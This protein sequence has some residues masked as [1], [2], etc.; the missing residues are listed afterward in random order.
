ML[1]KSF[2]D[3]NYKQLDFLHL[4]VRLVLKLTM[5][6]HVFKV[7]NWRELEWDL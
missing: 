5:E 2:A 3:D 7:K 1:W 6:N 4:F